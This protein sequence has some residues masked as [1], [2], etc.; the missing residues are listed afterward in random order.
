MAETA[1]VGTSMQ[2]ESVSER[3]VTAVAEFT[4]RDPLSLDPLY[5]A[6]DPEAL[7]ALFEPTDATGTPRRVAFTYA[8]CSVEIT[9]EGEI[10][11]TDLDQT[12]SP[13][14]RDGDHVGREQGSTFD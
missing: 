14:D 4:G 8:G 6:I 10:R 5:D 13:A 2:T 11:V 1:T 12:R 7:D 9:G 3:I